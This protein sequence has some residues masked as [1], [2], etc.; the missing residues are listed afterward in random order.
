MEAIDGSMLLTD[1]TKLMRREGGSALLVFCTLGS[2]PTRLTSN[3]QRVHAKE[4]R[5]H[6]ESER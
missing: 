3:P 6:Y 4:Y 5:N 1:R 2:D